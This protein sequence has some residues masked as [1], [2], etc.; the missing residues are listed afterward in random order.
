MLSVLIK[1]NDSSL[2]AFLNGLNLK[3]ASREQLNIKLVKVTL[4]LCRYFSKKSLKTSLAIF[5]LSKGSLFLKIRTIGK[6]LSSLHCSNCI[7]LATSKISL[8]TWV[9][10]LKLWRKLFKKKNKL[11]RLNSWESLV[12][13]RRKDWLRRRKRKKQGCYAIPPLLGQTPRRIKV[14]SP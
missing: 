12:R 11:N 3:I 13:L 6:V 1:G 4:V 2:L 9:M 10:A 5:P 8:T 14:D 7:N